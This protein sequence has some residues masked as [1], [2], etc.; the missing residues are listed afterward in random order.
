MTHADTPHSH[1]SQ[2]HEPQHAERH[3]CRKT[4]HL[5][6]IHDGLD[7]LDFLDEIA[8]WIANGVL[9]GRLGE[10]RAKLERFVFKAM[11][12]DRIRY[13]SLTP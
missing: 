9:P 12:K 1:A 13:Y 8:G 5:E 6:W 11:Q 4:A 2:Q 3:F 7:H 10:D